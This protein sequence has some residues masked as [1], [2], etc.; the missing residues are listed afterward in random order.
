M[1]L[2]GPRLWVAGNSRLAACLLALAVAGCGNDPAPAP[3][4]AAYADPG[5][6]EAGGWR[7]RYAL[8]QSTDLPAG[9]A[10]SYGIEQRRNLALLVV[11][12]ERSDAPAGT[13]AD[14]QAI[15]SESI[16]LTGARRALPL[17]RHDEPGGP[18]WLAPVELRHR[19]PLTIEIRARADGA[20]PT[21]VARLTREFRT[22]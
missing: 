17:S 13:R 2:S 18:T 21:I 14:A 7:M 1:R 5:F 12:L 15:E 9:I 16:A 11:T 22:E 3:P 20:S 8:T 4:A 6:V 10:G 19:V